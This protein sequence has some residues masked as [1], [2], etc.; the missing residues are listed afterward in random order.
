MCVCEERTLSLPSALPQAIYTRRRCFENWKSPFPHCP[1]SFLMLNFT[2]WLFCM[3]RQEFA[4]RSGIWCCMQPLSL[5]VIPLPSL[6]NKV[7][8]E[9]YLRVKH[10]AISIT[11]AFQLLEMVMVPVPS[12]DEGQ[13]TT[14][15][16][17]I[18]YDG[19]QDAYYSEHAVFSL[20]L[21]V[22]TFFLGNNRSMSDSSAQVVINSNSGQERTFLL[23]LRCLSAFSESF[24]TVPYARNFKI[25]L[26]MRQRML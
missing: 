14:G 23:D 12:L 1:C 3:H 4:N 26:N 5:L 21:H 19:Q 22:W 6:N 7:N 25:K 13:P 24:Q 9:V 20:W 17:R 10:P 18:R 8:E 11:M 16:L 15:V 2:T